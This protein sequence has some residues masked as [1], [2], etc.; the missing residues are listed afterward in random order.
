M[1]IPAIHHHAMC[2]QRHPAPPSCNYNTKVTDSTKNTA[3]DFLISAQVL[4]EIRYFKQT[5]H[6]CYPLTAGL[7]LENNRDINQDIQSGQ[8]SD[9]F[10]LKNNKY[11]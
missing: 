11:S 4:L 3:Q 8:I 9:T 7:A 10:F 6:L 1:V 5:K 2:P